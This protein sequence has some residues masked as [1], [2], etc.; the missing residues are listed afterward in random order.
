MTT[1]A[2][3]ERAILRDLE[4]H[5]ARPKLEK[6]R[7][8][9]ER[10]EYDHYSV[11]RWRVLVGC[12]PGH[13]PRAMRMGQRGFF[14]R[15]ECCARELDSIG[16]RYCADCMEL[17]APERRVPALRAAASAR[18]CQR[19]GCEQS[20]PQRSRADAK[21]CSEACARK[22]QNARRGAQIPSGLS[23][24]APSS[25][26]TPTRENHQQNQWSILRLKNWPVN[27]VGGHRRPDDLTL[28]PA[29]VGTILHC[30]VGI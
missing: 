9:A 19:A 16:L 5:R 21:Y 3:V 7:P 17:P 25:L 20:I 18:Q 8:T 22:V 13:L 24:T 15:C 11:R 10:P 14:I 26:S 6:K 29:L 28:D 23:D 4:Q 12:D 2:A 30:E 27:V 1:A